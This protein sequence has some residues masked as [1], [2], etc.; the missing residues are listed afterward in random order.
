[1]FADFRTQFGRDMR[2]G[3]TANSAAL[4]SDFPELNELVATF[5]GASFRGGLYRILRSGDAGAWRDRVAIA[6][7]EFSGRAT[8]FGFDWLGR[9]FALDTTRTE[10]RR[11]AVLMFDVGAG[12]ALE[13]PTNV[14][15]FHD[16]ELVE[17]TDAALAENFHRKWLR[18]GGAEPA[19]DQCV[20]Y[21]KPLFLGGTD[22]LENL[23][24]SD[25]DVYWHVTGQLRAKTRGV[26][27]G[28]RVRTTIE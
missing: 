27:V 9:A 5:G 12:E 4:R 23:E 26:P 20:G 14:E 15:S 3:P 6:F 13:V 22:E 25:L 10:D 21:K 28:T 8:C 7:P 18:S 11:A 1:M 17:Y 2:G 24:L 16:S 19:F